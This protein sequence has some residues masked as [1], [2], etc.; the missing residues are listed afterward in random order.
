MN[1][2]VAMVTFFVVV[3][4]GFFFAGPVAFA[5]DPDVEFGTRID[6]A[7]AYAK[8]GF[9]HDATQELRCAIE[10]K[11]GQISFKA[12]FMLGQ[13]CFKEFDLGCSL[14]MFALAQRLITSE[15]EAAKAGAVLDYLKKNFG[16]VEFR[17]SIEGVT[18]G[19]LQI[20]PQDPI[21]DSEL[22]RYFTEKVMPLGKASRSLPWSLYLPAGRYKINQFEFEM[23]PLAEQWDGSGV[24][25]DFSYKPVDNSTKWRWSHAVSIGFD[26]IPL[27][28]FWLGLMLSGIPLSYGKPKLELEV[29]AVFGLGVASGRALPWFGLG[30]AAG[31][32][33]RLLGKGSRFHWSVGAMA[34]F[35]AFATSCGPL[36]GDPAQLNLTCGINDGFQ[37]VIR[38]PWFGPTAQVGVIA[39]IG[40]HSYGLSLIF[41]GEV[42]ALGDRERT[43]RVP[44]T[45]G[46]VY[47]LPYRFAGGSYRAFVPIIGPSV[48]FEW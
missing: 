14:Q 39:P 30:L 18:E 45:N 11:E 3:I 47:T 1:R 34:G 6:Q 38:S 23:L 8:Q 26:G 27:D 13:S 28:G 5:C 31:G 4:F 15:D 41:I 48:D 10:T 25:A 19:Y 12:H 17:S 44:A 43:L 42:Y 9:Y 7:Q 24:T 2:T 35:G 29:P 46:Q 33:V 21:I 32:D 20:E 16:K 40:R 37:A 22:N 36:T